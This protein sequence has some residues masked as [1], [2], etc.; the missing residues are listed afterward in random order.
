MPLKLALAVRG[1]VAVRR[2]GALKMG[3]GGAF[4]PSNAS[5]GTGG[6]PHRCAFAGV[7]VWA[8]GRP[9]GP[10]SSRG[11]TARAMEPDPGPLSMRVRRSGDGPAR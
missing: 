3:G 10:S 6:P 7:G 8:K 11:Q 9:R 1:T 4:P 2:L 5:L